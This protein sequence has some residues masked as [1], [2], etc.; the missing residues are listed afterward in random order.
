MDMLFKA[1]KPFTG[2]AGDDEA[3]LRLPAALFM[4]MAKILITLCCLIVLISCAGREYGRPATGQSSAPVAE[5]HLS[6]VTQLTFEGD[7]GEAYFSG[8]GKLLIYQSNRGGYSCDKIWIMKTDGSDQRMVSPGH[9]AHTCS[10]FYPDSERIIFSSTSHLKGDCPPRPE[11]VKGTHYV[12]PLYP[13][14]IFSA[15]PDGTDLKKLTD[16]PLYDAEPILSPDGKKIV[17][18]SQ[19]DGDFDI[20]IMNSDGTNV[21]RLTDTPGYDGGPWFSPDGK[22][23]VWRAW[24]PQTEKEKGYGGTAW[25]RTTSSPFPLTY[26]SWRRTD[27]TNGC[28][29]GTGRRTGHPHGILTGSGS[30]SRQIWTTGDRR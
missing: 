6:N 24:H 21:K 19:R 11:A 27:R 20:Y 5:R 12:W 10:F 17:F 3:D 16:N 15:R 28:S 29:C 8:D 9:G 4:T 23:I 13:Y 7:N 1:D 2:V 30:S 18:G 22:R 26:G 25:K 14:D